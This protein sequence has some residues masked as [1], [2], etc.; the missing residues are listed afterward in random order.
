MPPPSGKLSEMKSL[1]RSKFAIDLSSQTSISVLRASR[2]RMP[3][4]VVSFNVEAGSCSS[5]VSR[6]QLLE[7][8]APLSPD[9]LALQGLQPPHAADD[10]GLPEQQ[11]AGYQT[12]L[13]VYLTHTRHAS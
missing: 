3:L 5:A 2:G 6:A 1:R 13:P 11:A 9:L 4:T 12:D 10:K 7:T 8:L